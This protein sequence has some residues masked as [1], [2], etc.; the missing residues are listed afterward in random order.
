MEDPLIVVG[1][2]A[3]GPYINDPEFGVSR[4][5]SCAV[6]MSYSNQ[7]DTNKGA[8]HSEGSVPSTHHGNLQIRR[9]AIVWELFRLN[10]KYK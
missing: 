4:E 3:V 7:C 8:I 5:V 10:V 2:Y 1:E 6:L 9:N